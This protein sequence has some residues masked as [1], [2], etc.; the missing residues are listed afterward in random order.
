[1][2]K[3]FNEEY[4]SLSFS[5]FLQLR[6]MFIVDDFENFPLYFQG[7]GNIISGTL[8]F[9]FLPLIIVYPFV[10]NRHLQ[11]NFNK[12]NHKEF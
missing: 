9:V 8:T 7:A 12:L 6:Q 5:V 10:L 11:K 2:L 4:F 1:M 3:L